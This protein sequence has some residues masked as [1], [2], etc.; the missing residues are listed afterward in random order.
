MN[1]FCSCFSTIT[2]PPI[3]ILFIHSPNW[4]YYNYRNLD[5][6]PDEEFSE[7]KRIDFHKG[8]LKLINYPIDKYIIKR[9]DNHPDG[10]IQN[11]FRMASYKKTHRL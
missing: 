4:T 2:S 1:N 3:H 8:L 9:Y 6:Q 7:E 10:P 5:C 11:I